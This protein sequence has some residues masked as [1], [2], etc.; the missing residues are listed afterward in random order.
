M[1]PAT[2]YQVGALKLALELATPEGHRPELAR[3]LVGEA[4]TVA[5]L[6]CLWAAE[7][8]LD[9][10]QTLVELGFQ[11]LPMTTWLDALWKLADLWLDEV[12]PRLRTSSGHD[13]GGASGRRESGA[14]HRG[15]WWSRRRRSR[16]R[17]TPHC[18]G[19]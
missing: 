9:P 12:W 11:A 7:R 4:F 17:S 16:S 5:S 1:T 18:S 10:Y 14:G 13:G 6:H 19:G 15:M 2:R 3:E 8:G